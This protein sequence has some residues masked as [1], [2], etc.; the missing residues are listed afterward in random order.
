MKIETEDVVLIQPRL[1]QGSN[2]LRIQMRIQLLFVC[3]EA[4]R[5]PHQCRR[6]HSSQQNRGDDGETMPRD[7]PRNFPAQHGPRSPISPWLRE[8]LSL[9]RASARP[10]DEVA[11][12]NTCAG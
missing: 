5:Q 12:W 11:S 3:V 10:R 4:W 8:S 2:A 1:T 9:G 6:E 7:F